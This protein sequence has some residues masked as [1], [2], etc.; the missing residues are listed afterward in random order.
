MFRGAAGE[1]TLP[2]G[3]LGSAASRAFHLLPSPDI[4]REAPRTRLRWWCTS[5]RSAFST[6]TATR[7]G[8]RGWTVPTGASAEDLRPRYRA[9]GSCRFPSS[10]EHLVLNEHVSTVHNVRSHK[11]QT[12]LN[13]IHPE[14]FPHLQT[15]G[16][17]VAVREDHASGSRDS[18]AANQPHP[19]WS[20]EPSASFC[21]TRGNLKSSWFC[22]QEP[23]ASLHVPIVRAE[24]L[25]KFQFR[26][27]LEWQR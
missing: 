19:D 2:A 24:C 27:V 11:I 21:E 9:F 17:T 23:Q 10:T 20:T 13:M 25:L 18:S 1:V 3:F 5:P 8:W 16:T 7:P 22:P 14:I 15:C 26:P 6:R 4:R 12:Q